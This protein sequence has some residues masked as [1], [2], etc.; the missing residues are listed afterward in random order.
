MVNAADVW[1]NLREMFE[2]HA[3]ERFYSWV[4]WGK[5]DTFSH[6]YGPD[7]ER[8][9][10]EFAGFTRRC[11]GCSWIASAHGPARARS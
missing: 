1:I 7:D 2:D 9:A 8:P 11:S 3:D 5:V 6:R 10:A 4:Y